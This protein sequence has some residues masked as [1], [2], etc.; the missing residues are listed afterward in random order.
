MKLSSAAGFRSNES[1][2]RAGR[3]LG[4]LICSPISIGIVLVVW[5]IRPLLSLKLFVLPQ[6]I[7]PL[8]LAVADHVRGSTAKVSNH[9]AK[10]K[11]P[12]YLCYAEKT[13]SVNWAVVNEFRRD[14]GWIVLPRLIMVP[15]MFALRR[16]GPLSNLEYQQGAEVRETQLV[17]ESFGLLRREVSAAQR[18]SLKLG[19][20]VSID[21]PIISWVNRD[22]KYLEGL[23]LETSHHEYR[24]CSIR[25]YSMAM[26]RALSLGYGCI[27]IG[28]LTE[29]PLVL[30]HEQFLDYSQSDIRSDKNDLHIAKCS[31]LLI[32]CATGIDFLYTLLGVPTVCVNL[33]TIDARFAHH[34]LSLPKHLYVDDGLTTF[35]LPIMALTSRNLKWSGHRPSLW[36]GLP[37]RLGENSPEEIEEALVLALQLLGDPDERERH[38][39]MWQ[40]LWADF[41][42]RAKDSNLDETQIGLRPTLVLPNSALSRFSSI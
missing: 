26:S 13:D 20:Q 8:L 11:S 9:K 22:S 3:R 31:D 6:R 10:L 41:W 35:E 32:T 18:F 21:R 23:G 34:I 36:K 29:E 16:I 33:P 14:C 30:T 42:M 25:N 17:H 38:R 28:R 15:A 5:L 37:V 12:R 7:G 19:T 40:P 2:V 39:T 27:R 1:L 4:Y 24:N